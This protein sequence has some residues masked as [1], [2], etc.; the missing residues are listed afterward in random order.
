MRPDSPDAIRRKGTTL[1]L[2]DLIIAACALADEREAFTLD[3]YLKNIPGVKLHP[4]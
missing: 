2:S 1:P 4:P 3:P